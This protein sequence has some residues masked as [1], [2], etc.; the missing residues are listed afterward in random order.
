M[1]QI[2]INVNL[3]L[4]LILGFHKNIRYKNSLNKYSQY[5]KNDY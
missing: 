4:L 2:L 5:I 1:I 3:K